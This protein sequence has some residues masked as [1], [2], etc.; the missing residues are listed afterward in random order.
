MEALWEGHVDAGRRPAHRAS[1]RDFSR[2]TQPV[3]RATN[4]K[5]GLEMSERIYQ[6][7]CHT[8]GHTWYE[9]LDDLDDEDLTIYK[10]ADEAP[11]T[12][13]VRCPECHTTNVFTDPEV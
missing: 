1:D 10:N 12:Y 8:C 7:T 6:I 11:P 13:R 5:E 3:K 4:R 9:N 2:A